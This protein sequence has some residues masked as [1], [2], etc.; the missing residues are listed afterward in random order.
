MKSHPA[1]LFKGC[2][3]PAKPSAMKIGALPAQCAPSAKGISR[4]AIA[5]AAATPG[6]TREERQRQH[7]QIGAPVAVGLVQHPREG[8]DH[9]LRQRIGHLI[10]GH[11][12][13][14]VG[15]VV[16]P[17]LRAA[18]DPADQ[19]IVE[20]AGE[21]VREVE[22]RDARAEADERPPAFGP[23]RPA[24]P[25]A[26]G[27]PHEAGG[28]QRPGQLAAEQRPVARLHQRPG[29]RRAEP[30]H[31]AHHA[32]D[33]DATVFHPPVQKRRMLRA[34]P[35]RGH[36]QR[37]GGDQR[38]DPRFLIEEGHE[39]RD[40]QQQQRQRGREGD[41]DPEEEV[42]LLVPQVGLLH[43]RL[44]EAEILQHPDQRQHRRAHGHEAEF[45]GREQA[46]QDDH[47]SHLRGHHH[48][49]RRG[50]GR[51]AAADGGAQRSLRRIE[52]MLAAHRDT[53]PAQAVRQD[54]I[55]TFLPRFR[56]RPAR[57][58][59]TRGLRTKPQGAAKFPDVQPGGLRHAQFPCRCP[60]ERHLRAA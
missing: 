50:D 30:R 15:T 5:V 19:H 47:R 12:Q 25:P 14:L 35:V 4:S 57:D 26:R 56:G 41:I 52:K 34:Q 22:A 32:D 44:H 54:R 11:E 60:F 6:R 17:E 7:A 36:D 46:R 39:R 42:H 1:G 55:E 27:E 16:K 20:V 48:R 10:Q 24:R 21:E 3:S 2:R 40:Q 53:G 45:L 49:L 38:P 9:H 18:P 8:R 59:P 29:R 23:A 28:Q 43:R 33:G 51:G 31:R 13:E 58:R 37:H